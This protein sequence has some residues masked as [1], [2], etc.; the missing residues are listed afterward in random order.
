MCDVITAI[1]ICTAPL[2]STLK[3]V[4]IS[5]YLWKKYFLITRC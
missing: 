5:S 2:L 4:I 1:A 3:V